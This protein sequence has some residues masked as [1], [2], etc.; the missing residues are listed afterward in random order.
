MGRRDWGRKTVPAMTTFA[1]IDGN[2]FYASCERVF[3]PDLAGRPIVVLSNNDGCVVA[4]SAEAKALPGLRMFGPYFE[5]ADVC[6]QHDVAVF[7]SN[8]ALYGDMSRRMMRVLAEF[9][10]VQE[11]Y[12]IDECFLDVTGMDGREF[13]LHGYRMREA[14][15]RRVGIPTCVGIGPSKTLAKLANKLAKKL[16]QFAGVFSWDW[17]TPAEADRFMAGIRAGDV[18]GIGGRLAEQLQ[19][20][21]IC[22]ALHLKQADPR[23]IKRRFNVVVERTVAELNGVSCLELEDVAPS[24]QQIIASRSF[25]QKVK[26]LDTLTASVSHHAARAAEKLRAQGSTA[27]MVAVSISTSPFSD[28]A[29][30]RGYIVVPLIQASD[31]TIEITRAAL[32]GLRAIY[33]RGYLYHKAGIM[34]LEI[35]PRGV[36]QS[37]LFATPPDPRRRQLMGTLDAINREFGRGTLL[38]A[39]EALTPRWQMRQD[40]RSPR[41]T[42]RLDELLVV[43]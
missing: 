25:S 2:S 23:Q 35:G 19:A 29:Q 41:Y 13:D 20:M 5:I 15:L 4:A 30:Y 26:D 9:A 17:G 34:L 27:R 39:S 8:Y 11:V 21:G 32:A 43:A 10:P 18:W 36:V 3:R 40:V 16:P 42:T 24:K 33:R 28:V 22:S 38:L 31:D 6:R 7:S 12:S 14:V 37:D 1:L